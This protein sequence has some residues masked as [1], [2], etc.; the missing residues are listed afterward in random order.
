M[1]IENPK[2]RTALVGGVGSEG[3]ENR[4][5]IIAISVAKICFKSCLKIEQK[6][7][8][9]NRIFNCKVTLKKMVNKIQGDIF[10]IGII[11]IGKTGS[12]LANRIA[13]TSSEETPYNLHLSFTDIDSKK[14]KNLE[15]SLEEKKLRQTKKIFGCYPPERFMENIYST[16][17][18]FF[19]AT[20]L[21][22]EERQ[23]AVKEKKES[24]RL[25]ETE[26]NLGLV[27][28]Y[29]S[30]FKEHFEG[31]LVVVSNLTDILSYAFALHSKMDPRRI[32]GL[33]HVDTL[34]LRGKLKTWLKDMGRIKKGAEVEVEAYAIGSHEKPFC[35]VDKIFANEIRLYDFVSKVSE[36]NDYIRK[37]GPEHLKALGGTAFEVEEA[38]FQTALA[39]MNEDR[40]ITAS[41]PYP[42][43]KP[44]CYI[45]LPVTFNKGY[46]FLLDDGLWF[47]NLSDN[48]R[49]GF[50]NSLEE[51]LKSIDKLKEEGLIDKQ[52]QIPIPKERKISRRRLERA[53]EEEPE[54]T[55]EEKINALVFAPSSHRERINMYDLSKLSE[56][57]IKPIKSFDAAQPTFIYTTNNSLFVIQKKPPFGMADDKWCYE[58]IELDIATGKKQTYSTGKEL[59][60]ERYGYSITSLFCLENILYAACDNNNNV[61]ILAWKKGSNDMNKIFTL[62]KPGKIFSVAARRLTENEEKYANGKY[63]IYGAGGG[64][65][66]F[67]LDTEE[68]EFGYDFAL[69]DRT[70]SQLNLK[71][72]GRHCYIGDK[73]KNMLYILH[74]EKAMKYKKIKTSYGLFDFLVHEKGIDLALVKESGDKFRIKFKTYPDFNN[75]IYEK[76]NENTKISQDIGSIDPINYL[77]ITR[78]HIL[79]AD[80]NSLY[81]I[82]KKSKNFNIKKLKLDNANYLPIFVKEK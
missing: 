21:P 45:G 65:L 37:E 48:A 43:E 60:D 62:K 51:I 57:P 53:K 32:I 22:L 16:D 14:V 59:I 18:I 63:L 79:F 1:R 58:I 24:G 34:R 15:E 39:I 49:E 61:G 44:G 19:T 73:D 4:K 82:E 75:L 30:Y 36:I 40:T 29:A 9:L 55:P 70:D 35:V 76:E 20:K 6:P 27:K 52:L 12:A 46:P 38:A 8:N 68:E 26:K 67:W 31:N 23:K 17:I 64:K 71:L 47:S 81:F 56:K 41:I 13:L 66:H 5:M 77:K 2:T 50:Q 33:N 80:L 72:D 78:D 3:A 69:T 42:P 28:G 7:Q 74:N 10:K 54:K 25:L 11:G